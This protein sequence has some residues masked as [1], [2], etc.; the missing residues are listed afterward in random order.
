MKLIKF[1]YQGRSAEG[2]VI[3]D[4]V[5]VI[6]SW[7]SAAEHPPFTLPT[8]SRNDLQALAAECKEVVPLNEI[9]F[10]APVG[11][12]SKIICLG[13]NYKNHVDETNAEVGPTPPLFARWSDS[14]VGHDIPLIAPYASD[15]YDFEGEIAVVIGKRGRRISK[16]EADKHILGYTCFFDG[17]LRAY[18]KHSPTAGKNFPRSGSM[19]PW[20]V[21]PDEAGKPEQFVLETRINGSIVQS[22]V[23]ALMIFDIPTIIA[24]VS[25]FT[26]LNPGTLLQQVRRA[27]SAQSVSHHYG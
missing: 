25:E 18:Q 11:P 16:S 7:N 21:T 9:A 14:L 15:T 24:Y 26:E 19:G 2:V 23:G 20:I 27:A 13:F 5:H 22:T 4:N 3:G 1:S 17:S 8:Y 10:A 6:T 12:A